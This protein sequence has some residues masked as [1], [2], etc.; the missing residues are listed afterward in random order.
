MSGQTAHRIETPVSCARTDAAIAI[1]ELRQQIDVVDA[2]LLWALAERMS[3]VR[4]IGRHKK[5]ASMT[6][7]Q[8]DRWMKLVAHRLALGDHLGLSQDFVLALFERIH[9]EAIRVQDDL[10]QQTA[11]TAELP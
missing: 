1:E 5:T 9:E 6:T 7:V 8:I 3:L 2:A 4:Q 11:E 10:M